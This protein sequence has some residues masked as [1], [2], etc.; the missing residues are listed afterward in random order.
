MMKN[1]V[2]DGVVVSIFG[3]MEISLEEARTYVKRGRTLYGGK[4]AGMSLRVDM[5]EPEMIEIHYTLKKQPFERI[6]RINGRMKRGEGA[7]DAV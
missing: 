4:L 6:R 7:A 5:D 3:S 1:K 2:I